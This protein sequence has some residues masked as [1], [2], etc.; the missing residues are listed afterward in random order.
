[1]PVF[2]TLVKTGVLTFLAFWVVLIALYYIQKYE[3]NK[4][5]PA[6]YYRVTKVSDGDTIEVDM[7]GKLE[8]VR[9]IGVDT[10]ETHHPKKEVECYGQ[11][12]SDFT[13]NALDGEVV[14]LEADDTNQN[15]DRYQ[16]LL[17]YVYTADGTLWN[18]KLLADGYGHALT[19]FPFT[20]M[21]EFTKSEIQAREL[22]KGLWSACN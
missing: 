8:K 9:L 17:R 12:A 18:K 22:N 20:K 21:D 11:L 15:R 2:K 1:M 6:G 16:R 3:T 4:T 14:R 10:P 7:D 19:A 13:K 5:A